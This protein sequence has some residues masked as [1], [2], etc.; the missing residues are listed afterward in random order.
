MAET[1]LHALR[2]HAQATPDREVLR[3]V[4]GGGA[5]ALGFGALS[6][7]VCAA[8]ARIA[9]ATRRGDRVLL[10]LPP[11]LD[12]MV[13]FLGCLRAGRVAVPAYPPD[14][15]R[16][17]RSLARLEAITADARPAAALTT[18]AL[19]A[20]AP[21][22][23]DDRCPSL[24]ALAWHPVD[25]LGEADGFDGTMPGAGALAYLQYTSGSTAAPK[26][27][28][29]HHRHLTANIAMIGEALDT[30]ASSVTV[31]WLPPYHDMGL[32]TGI[33]MPIAQGAR[34][35]HISPV[36]FLASPL[37]WL[38]LISRYRGTHAAAPDF[39]YRR[40][41]KRAPGGRRRRAVGAGPARLARGSQRSGARPRRHHPRLQRHLRPLRPAPGGADALLWP[42][43]VCRR[44]LLHR[45]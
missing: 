43:R 40:C 24:R 36:D 26:G 45:A 44:G 10:L 7:R 17:E 28:C 1:I 33:L 15:G 5:H 3:F 11:G 34:A 21:A 23:L 27:V 13:A 14:P 32:V 20:M 9:A 2:A 30:S 16:L 6:R 8:A 25:E 4:D 37:R 22:V 38:E 18:A 29:I 42:R 12:Y 41:V 19:A 31:S 39:A 35:I